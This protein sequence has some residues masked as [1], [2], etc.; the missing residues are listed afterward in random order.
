[1]LAHRIRQ[2]HHAFPASKSVQDESLHLGSF[3]A[4]TAHDLGQCKNK[5]REFLSRKHE[6]K[7]R[8]LTAY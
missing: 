4:Y 8:I 2:H 3:K 6:N 5:C 7:D 1:M